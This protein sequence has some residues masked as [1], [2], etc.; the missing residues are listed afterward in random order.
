MYLR[1]SGT[2][3]DGKAINAA[4]GI[5][6]IAVVA[7]H[8]S[9]Q[10]FLPDFYFWHVQLFFFLAGAGLVKERSPWE[11]V[12]HIFKGVLVYLVAWNAAYYVLFMG[13]GG[14]LVPP[15]ISAIYVIT[16]GIFEYNSHAIG[17]LAPLWFLIAYGG[18]IA[19]S[20]C[21]RRM[22]G[23]RN[24]LLALAGLIFVYIGMACG[25]PSGY[26]FG[27][28]QR[29]IPGYCL[30]ASGYMLIGAWFFSCQ[31]AQ[32]LAVRPVV[33]LVSLT[34]FLWLCGTRIASPPGFAWMDVGDHHLAIFLASVLGIIPVLA[35]STHL[36]RIPTVVLVGSKSKAIMTHHLLVFLGINAFLFAFGLADAESLQPYQVINPSIS[37]PMYVGAGVFLSLAL[38]LVVKSV[39]GRIKV[40]IP[41]RLIFLF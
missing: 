7:G 19:I 25:V 27:E 28:W 22:L 32:E 16:V 24:R 30:I 9:A 12:R 41:A 40:L 3:F 33:A 17:V 11:V 35:A 6:I 20:A 4:R 36:S 15:D 26:A 38:D 34:A 13:L 14:G 5:G 31:K 21:V 37:W 18:G 39:L 29:I 1:M 23:R 10:F 2:F 8:T